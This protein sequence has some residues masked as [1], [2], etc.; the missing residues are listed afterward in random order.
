MKYDVVGEYFSVDSSYFETLYETD[1]LSAA[2][3]WADGYTKWGDFGGYHTIFV[4]NNKTYDYE[5]ELT[6]DDTHD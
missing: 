3:R 1:S 6:Q 4:H 2:I 5:Y